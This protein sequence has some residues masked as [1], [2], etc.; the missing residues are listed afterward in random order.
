MHQDKFIWSQFVAKFT[1]IY[2]FDYS[3]NL[4]FMVKFQPKQAHFNKWQTSL[5]CKVIHALEEGEAFN[6]FFNV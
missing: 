3:E 5:H 6:D 1:L 2:N 4:Q